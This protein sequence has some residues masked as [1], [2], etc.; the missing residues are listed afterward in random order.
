MTRLC[1]ITLRAAG[2]DPEGLKD[3]FMM[4]DFLMV[5]PQVCKGASSRTV[6]IPSGKWLADD[7]SFV[8]GPSRITVRTPLSRLPYFIRQGQG[9]VDKGGG[10]RPRRFSYC[11]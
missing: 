3:Q 7:G 8:E 10:D 5:A 2:T 6:A 9:A 11:R 4:G 1:K